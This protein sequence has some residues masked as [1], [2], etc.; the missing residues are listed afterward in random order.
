MI[1]EAIITHFA[2]NNRESHCH[3]LEHVS[4]HHLHHCSIYHGHDFVLRNVL[5]KASILIP[6]RDYMACLISL[7][8]K[9][10]LPP[11]FL[12]C[13]KL[14]KPYLSFVKGFLSFR[15]AFFAPFFA[16]NLTGSLPFPKD[17]GPN[18]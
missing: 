5:F 1:L 16:P 9:F 8:N 18:I 3:Q 17:E 11:S 2:P 6:S 12:A 7:N 14:K 4:L 13:L 15:L 10:R